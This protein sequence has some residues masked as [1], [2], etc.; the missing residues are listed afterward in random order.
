MALFN[1]KK[2]A[3]E[4]TPKQTNE[5]QMSRRQSA[6]RPTIQ[7]GVEQ[8]MAQRGGMMPNGAVNGFNAL[9]QVIGKEQIGKKID[10]RFLK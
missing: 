3:E 5:E 1:R 9:A 10:N 4:E 7:D 2:N 6:P 8:A